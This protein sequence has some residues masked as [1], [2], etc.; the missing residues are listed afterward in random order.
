[1]SSKT[2]K[3]QR[4]ANIIEVSRAGERVIGQIDRATGKRVPSAD[5]K[6]AKAGKSENTA[7]K[8]S[9]R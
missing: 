9:D 5:E 1:M 4:L 8:G 6:P 3:P 2:E 7:D